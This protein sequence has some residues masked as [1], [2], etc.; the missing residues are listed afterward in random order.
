LIIHGERDQIV[1]VGAAKELAAQLP[2]NQLIILPE[3]GHVP[4]MTHPQAV[5]SAINAFFSIV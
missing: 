1:P 3:A 2:N 4:T 5:T